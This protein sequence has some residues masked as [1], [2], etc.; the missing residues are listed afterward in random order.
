MD[1]LD[2]CRQFA[3]WGPT[4]T[5]GAPLSMKI[6]SARVS[7]VCAGCI[8]PQSGHSIFMAEGYWRRK[9]PPPQRPFRELLVG[10]YDRVPHRKAL[11]PPSMS[12]HAIHPE[13]RAV[14]MLIV[15]LIRSTAVCPLS[16][17]QE[18][19]GGLALAAALLGKARPLW[20]ERR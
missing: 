17:R 15:P 2:Q 13:G 18:F 4:S 1:C 16:L 3:S 19:G 6:T 9:R 11:L 8:R 20:E 5:S 14:R 10:A 12:M 7:A